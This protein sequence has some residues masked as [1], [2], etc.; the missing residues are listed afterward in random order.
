MAQVGISSSKGQ[1]GTMQKQMRLLLGGHLVTINDATENDWLFSNFGDGSWIGFTDQITEGDWKWISGEE[2][3]YTNW[4]A[5]QPSNSIHPSN[6][7]DQDY[8]WM[9]SGFLGKWDDHFSSNDV[10]TSAT[11][12]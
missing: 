12:E 9:H 7:T 11:M 5:D 1:H 4:Y 6:G 2:V 10:G 8:G 3:T